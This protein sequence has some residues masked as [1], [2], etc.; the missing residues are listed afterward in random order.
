MLAHTLRAVDAAQS[1]DE[2]VIAAR[3][4]DLLTYA[5]LCKTYG[6][7]KPV[8]VVVG[9]ATR[10][11][12]VLRAALMYLTAAGGFLLRRRSGGLNALLMAL[13]VLLLVNPYSIASVGLQLSF[14]STLGLILF[15]GK[16]QHALEKPF[17]G[18]P[19]LVRKALAVITS[20]LS[21]TVCATIF[22]V[23]ILLTSFGAVSVLSPISN[24]MTV[25]VT[26]LCFVG[27]FVLCVAA[28]VC[29]ALVP[30][31][32]GLVRPLISYLL[33]SANTIADLGFGTLHPNNTFG[34][35]ALGIVFAA[36]LVWLVMFV[37]WALW[38]GYG[39]RAVGGMLWSGIRTAK[40]VLIVFLLVGVLTALWRACGTVPLLICYAVDLIH[41]GTLVITSF[42][43]ASA[44]SALMGTSFGAAATM[45][46]VCMTAAASMARR[47][48]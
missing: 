10:E 12:S 48:S 31:L 36:L 30:M 28:A 29:P 46:A 43:L 38:Q 21:C 41:P 14:A 15:A 1:V 20:A 44:V 13:A 32:A 40:N 7:R 25:G 22:T 24:L 45:G 8:K 47:C 5:E 16:L 39:L 6:I 35:A 34:L 9:G 18:A 23:P 33:W 26:S 42:L 2:I 11:E 37:G 19:K 27:G 17:A 3:D 4:E